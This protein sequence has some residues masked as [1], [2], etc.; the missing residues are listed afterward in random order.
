[1]PITIFGPDGE[2]SEYLT[3]SERLPEFQKRFPLDEGYRVIRSHESAIDFGSSVHKI[4]IEAL[5]A[6]KDP[7]QLGL[8]RL[9]GMG[10]IFTAE[11]Y[12]DEILIANASA[13]KNVANTKDWEAGE[14]ASFQRL[15]AATGLGGSDLDADD[16][17]DRITSG[18]EQPKPPH[19]RAQSNAPETAPP[20][21]EEPEIPAPSDAQD[22]PAGKPKPEPKARPK[23]APKAEI[24]DTDEEIRPQLLNQLNHVAA[25][26]GEPVPEVSN[27]AEAKKEIKR[28]TRK[29]QKG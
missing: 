7:V 6:G 21:V 11:L 28:L 16:Q 29:A 26:A 18:L 13:F 19:E 9:T 27:N 25:L 23:A 15:M 24:S 14:T 2:A 3:V 1:M 20:A 8:P 12:K 4:W 17:Y 10:V 22:E 5:Q